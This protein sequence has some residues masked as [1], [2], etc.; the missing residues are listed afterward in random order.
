[1]YRPFWM[2][3]RMLFLMFLSLILSFQGTSRPLQVA[4][5]LFCRPQ[6]FWTMVTAM[7]AEVGDARPNPA[8]CALTKLQQQDLLGPII[9]QNVDRLH[10]VTFPQCSKKL[11]HRQSHLATVA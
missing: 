6:L 7:M 11:H 2:T 5:P 8:H 1:M 9:T 3:G 4:L 10:Q